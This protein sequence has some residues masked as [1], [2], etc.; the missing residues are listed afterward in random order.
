M[1][2]YLETNVRTAEMLDYI[3]ESDEYRLLENIWPNYTKMIAQYIAILE[4]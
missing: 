2:Y 3:L 4:G 1:Y